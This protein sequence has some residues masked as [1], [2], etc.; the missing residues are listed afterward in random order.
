MK[1]GRENRCLPHVYAGKIQETQW[2]HGK[3]HTNIIQYINNTGYLLLS[4]NFDPKI[5]T[6]YE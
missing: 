5:N 4:T 2:K 3:A 1:Q 6:F